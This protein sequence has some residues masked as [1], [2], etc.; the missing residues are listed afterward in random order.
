MSEAY[1]AYQE[2][3]QIVLSNNICHTADKELIASVLCSQRRITHPEN[4]WF[5]ERAILT[6]R[7][8]QGAKINLDM[9]A[10]VKG[11]LVEYTSINRVMK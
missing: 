1:P 7:N 8:D 2:E 9:L 6:P 10:N 5:C 4:S 11:E 3:G